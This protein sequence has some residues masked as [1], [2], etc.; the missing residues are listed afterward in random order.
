MKGEPEM[1]HLSQSVLAELRTA[2]SSAA[3]AL[4]TNLGDLFVTP[5]GLGTI[6]LKVPLAAY[7]QFI[8]QL[9]VSVRP[10]ALWIVPQDNEQFQIA[11]L[12]SIRVQDGKT[13][14]DGQPVTLL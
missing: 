6:Q 2:V 3:P 14:V 10:R 9:A 12:A 7:L 5:S 4:S 1:P 13:F 11:V 8:D